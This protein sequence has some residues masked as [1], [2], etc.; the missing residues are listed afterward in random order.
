[1]SHNHIEFFP[2]QEFIDALINANSFDSESQLHVRIFELEL[3]DCYMEERERH[4]LRIRDDGEFIRE[5]WLDTHKKTQI[6]GCIVVG[7]SQKD[8]DWFIL[9]V[10]EIPRKRYK[11][12]GV[13]RI[14]QHYISETSSD[15]VLV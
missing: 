1:M 2:E 14:N 15:E 13:G 5:F 6:Q 3:R 10:T 4:V 8:D 7:K 11:R 9:L 12:F